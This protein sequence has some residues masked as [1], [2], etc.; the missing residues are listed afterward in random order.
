MKIDEVYIYICRDMSLRVIFCY[1]LLVDPWMAFSGRPEISHMMRR[2][3]YT[4]PLDQS[5]RGGR[6]MM[7]Y[8]SFGE[9]KE[10]SDDVRYEGAVLLITSHHLSEVFLDFWRSQHADLQVSPLGSVHRTDVAQL[11]S[12]EDGREMME[13]ADADENGGVSYDEFVEW[14]ERNNPGDEKPTMTDGW[15]IE[16]K[17]YPSCPSMLG[18]SEVEFR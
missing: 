11:R 8:V 13:R 18:H 1:S 2:L 16:G 10:E 5:Y 4:M 17:L 3:L 7:V 12:A 9:G 6:F 14:L 15:D